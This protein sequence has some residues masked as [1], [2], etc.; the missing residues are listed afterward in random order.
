M[1]DH[2]LRG[3]SRH[4]VQ[5][6][7]LRTRN[8]WEGHPEWQD[9]AFAKKNT[10]DPS[11]TSSCASLGAAATLPR[12]HLCRSCQHPRRG[13]NP[14]LLLSADFAEQIQRDRMQA[15]YPLDHAGNTKKRC[16]WH[17][18]CKLGQA[19]RGDGCPAPLRARGE[20]GGIAW[21]ET[22]RGVFMETYGHKY[23]N[24]KPIPT[25]LMW[26]RSHFGSR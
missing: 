4:R 18:I 19:L 6:G 9:S 17:Y 25:F 10:T 23:A 16:L 22:L 13:L 8:A 5:E 20:G 26:H 15:S 2:V 24:G 1:H 21:W 3:E 14:H 11:D 7:F 12:I